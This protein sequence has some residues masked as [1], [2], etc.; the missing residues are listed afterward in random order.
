ME[1]IFKNFPLKINPITSIIIQ[2]V[3]TFIPHLYRIPILRKKLKNEGKP[4][5][6]AHSRALSETALDNT[7]TGQYL[8]QLRGC[9]INGYESLIYYTPAVLSALVMKVPSDVVKGAA[10]L[11][12]VSRIIFT[13]I[14]MIPALNGKLRTV[15][16]VIGISAAI[17]LLISAANRYDYY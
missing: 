1:A 11:F 15:M 9:H 2:L 17:G 6:V 10:G 8:A 4:Y 16:F 5:D 14:Y 13:A 12:I 7:P 3:L